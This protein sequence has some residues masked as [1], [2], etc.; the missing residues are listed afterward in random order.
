VAKFWPNFTKS[1]RKGPE[2]NFLKKFLISS[3]DKHSVPKKKVNL[4]SIDPWTERC[5]DVFVKL[6]ELFLKLA[7][8]FLCTGRKQFRDLAT[9]LVCRGFSVGYK[10]EV[11]KGPE[12]VK[13]TV[14]AQKGR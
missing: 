6:A 9:L 5:I 14:S 4:I 3:N 12:K 1:G 13:Y 11:L 7:E 2:E 8:L 10:R